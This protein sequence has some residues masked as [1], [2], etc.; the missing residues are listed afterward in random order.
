MYDILKKVNPTT[1]I[2]IGSIVVVVVLIVLTSWS[3]KKKEHFSFGDIF[4]KIGQVGKNVGV[5]VKDTAVNVYDRVKPFNPSFV[6]RYW[7][8]IAW[9]CPQGSIDYGD[10]YNNNNSCL[11]SDL[12]PQVWRDNGGGKWGWGCPRGTTPNNDGDWNKKCVRGYISRLPMNGQWKCPDWAED[13]GAN[14]GNTDWYNAQ[15]QCKLNNTIFTMPYYEKSQNKWMCPAGYANTGFKWGDKFVNP[16]GSIS[17][18]GYAQCKLIG[19]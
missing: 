17:E 7:D 14:W 19:G 3:Q 11:T 2:L 4:K 12:G 13:T 10:G 18:G 16:D 5:L 15:K 1:L 8:G 9:T 6:P